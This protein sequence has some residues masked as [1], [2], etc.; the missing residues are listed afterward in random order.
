MECK[1]LRHGRDEAGDDQQLYKLDS[2]GQ[3]LRGV[4]GTTWMISA[5]AP[6]RS[7]QTRAQ[8]HGIRLI[9]PD[10]LPKL[11]DIVRHWKAH[12]KSGS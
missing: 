1:I 12:P 2:L 5:R 10:E 7:M 8:Q 6:T 3:T 11:R 9:G 4:F